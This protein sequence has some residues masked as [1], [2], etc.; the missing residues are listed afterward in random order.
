M[1]GSFAGVLS[2]A[3]CVDLALTRD[4][5]LGDGAARRFLGAIPEDD[6]TWDDADPAPHPPHVPVVLVHGDAD[7]T[8]PLALSESYFA[9][10]QGRGASVVLTRIPGAGHFDVIDPE[11]DAFRVTLESVAQLAPG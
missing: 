10:T 8:V 11:H 3:G 4:L 6:P 2:L 9:A 1:S 7:D 5:D